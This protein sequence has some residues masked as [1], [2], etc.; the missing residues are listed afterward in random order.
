[1][2]VIN[3]VGRE[4]ATVIAAFKTEDE[5]AKFLAFLNTIVGSELYET[6]TLNQ[7]IEVYVDT[8]FTTEGIFPEGFINRRT[9]QK[10]YNSRHITLTAVIREMFPGLF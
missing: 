9:D 5:V 1:M 8:E 2:R 7:E 10:V 6:M 3:I 4:R